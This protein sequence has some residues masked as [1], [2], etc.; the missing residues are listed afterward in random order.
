MY[1]NNEIVS[2]G[3]WPQ[4]KEMGSYLGRRGVCL[5]LAKQIRLQMRHLSI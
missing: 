2:K 3:I 4:Q 1:K 5:S